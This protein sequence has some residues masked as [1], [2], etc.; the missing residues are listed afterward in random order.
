M[1]PMTQDALQTALGFVVNQ[2]YTI[3]AT[4][5]ETVYPDYDYASLVPIDSSAPEWSGGVMTFI[6]DTNGKAEWFKGMAK[7]MPLAEM[8][9]DATEK[10]FSMAAIGYEYDLEEV[11]RAQFMGMPLQ[12]G[13]ALAARRAYEQFMYNL[14]ITGS[15]VKAYGG[16]VNSSGITGI[17]AP[18][19]GTGSS[20]YWVNKTPDLIL[21]DINLALTGIWTGSL[22]TEMADTLLLPYDAMVYLAQ[23]R[24]GTN[25]ETTLL[26]WVQRTNVRTLTGGGPLM[27]RGVRG[28]ENQ[29][30]SNQG[31]AVAYRRDPSVVKL[32]L[33]MPHRFLGVWQDGPLN[34]VVP[35]IFRTGGVEILRPAAFRYLDLIT[36]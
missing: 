14:T 6:S 22:Q 27:I 1:F 13:K 11:G 17:N 19:D 35:G 30:A 36:A 15:T 33:P 21:R 31:R 9:R 7:D 29:A 28:L 5:Y 2:A 4:V 24:I 32:H 18:A 25:L 23:T 12:A 8:A 10:A 20:P 3:N 26:E 34:F 16:L